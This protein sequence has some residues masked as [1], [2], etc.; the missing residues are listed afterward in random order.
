MTI[1][2]DVAIADVRADRARLPEGDLERPARMGTLARMEAFT[3]ESDRNPSDV[4]V[5]TSAGLD[6]E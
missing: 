1:P 4:N 2:L 3:R 5:S 6:P